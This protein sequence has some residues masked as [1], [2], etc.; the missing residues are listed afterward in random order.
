[1][2]TRLCK[3]VLLAGLLLLLTAPVALAGTY[4]DGGGEDAAPPSDNRQ[5]PLDVK[6]QELLQV[7]LEAKL[8]GKAYGKTHEVARGQFVQLALD[9]TGM[10]WTVMGEFKVSR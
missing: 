6:K 1:M 10:V 2:V 4:A 8:N 9:G 3:S 7:A 5:T